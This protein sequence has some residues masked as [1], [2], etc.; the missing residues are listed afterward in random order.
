MSS[1]WVAD[2]NRRRRGEKRSSKSRENI[3]DGLRTYYASD[4]YFRKRIEYLLDNYELDDETGCWEWLRAVDKDG[5]PKVRGKASR[6]MLRWSTGEDHSDKIA[7]HRCDNPS[8]INP[9]HLYWGTQRDNARDRVQA[10]KQNPP[11]PPMHGEDNPMFGIGPPKASH[12]ERSRRAKE[13][14]AKKSP[15]ERKRHADKIWES[16]RRNQD[17]LHE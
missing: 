4:A 12:E 16:R 6:W 3:S 1:P 5:Y 11:P 14:W 13:W 2:S 10:G 15:A 7:L 17:E 9:D 8:C